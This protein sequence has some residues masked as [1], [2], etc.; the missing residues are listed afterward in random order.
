MSLRLK[1]DDVIDLC[2]RDVITLGSA[3]TRHFPWQ[4]STTDT[5]ATCRTNWKP[6]IL[7]GQ[8][9]VATCYCSILCTLWICDS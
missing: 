4:H 8:Y 7:A 5:S 3:A 6:L 2:V 1:V 9:T